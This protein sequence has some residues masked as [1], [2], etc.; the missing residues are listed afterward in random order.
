M[1]P[2]SIDRGDAGDGDGRKHGWRRLQWGRGRSTAE[3]SSGPSL[4][5]CSTAKLQWGRGRSTAEITSPVHCASGDTPLQW[6]RGRSTAEIN[7]RMSKDAALRALQWGRGR[8]T[9]EINRRNRERELLFA[10]FNGAAVDRPRRYL[11]TDHDTLH[12]IV[13]QWGRGRSTAEI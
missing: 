13:L 7:S 4:M 11:K 8:S 12:A 6:G 2:R 1:G 5:S 10:G 9:A 3:I